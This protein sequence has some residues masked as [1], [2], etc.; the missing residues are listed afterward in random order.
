MKSLRGIFRREVDLL[1]MQVLDAVL[2]LAFYLLV[3]ML[4]AFGTRANDPALAGLSVSILWVG[5]VLSALLPLPRLFASEF[6]DGTLEQW[7]LASTPLVVI[8]AIKLFAHWCL[9]GLALAVMAVPLAVLLGLEGA[10]LGYLALGLMMGTAI[11]TLLGG[12]SACLLVGIPRAASVL[13]LLVLPLMAPV[14]IFGSG[15]V[16]AWQLGADPAAPLYFLGSLFAL[17]ATAL[18]W[19]C[20]S[21]LRN[22]YD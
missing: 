6:E 10:G 21:A 18:P 14:V 11:L 8:V 19:A 20:A 1:R 7:C 16:R 4:F 13:P 3:V 5:A 17:S 2:P 15:A 22:A 12:L 9:N